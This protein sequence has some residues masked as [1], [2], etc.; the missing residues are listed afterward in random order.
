MGVIK[1]NPHRS[2]SR[3][4][5]LKFWTL[6]HI[7]KIFLVFLLLPIAMT[8][9]FFYFANPEIYELLMMAVGSTQMVITG[10]LSF[11]IYLVNKRES[12]VPLLEFALTGVEELQSPFDDHRVVRA[13]IQVKNYSNGRA[14]IKDISTSHKLNQ[15]TL[16]KKD[17]GEGNVVIGFP[18]GKGTP[19]ILDFGQSMTTTIQFNGYKHFEDVNLHFEEETLGEIERELLTSDISNRLF[20]KRGEGDE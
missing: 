14:K 8:G 15:R 1:F 16:Q 4:I 20:L 6:K 5:R 11:M 7:S 18:E 2:E 10:Y 12:E 19:T 9:G 13:K 3:P 17:P